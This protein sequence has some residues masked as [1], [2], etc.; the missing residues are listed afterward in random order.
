M[1][2]PR[3]RFGF[4]RFVLALLLGVGTCWGVAWL[5]EPKPLWRMALSNSNFLSS[6]FTSSDNK[7]GVAYCFKIVQNFMAQC[8]N[9]CIYECQSGRILHD[10]QVEPE[11]FGREPFV[12]LAQPRIVN[13]IFWRLSSVM[14]EK[15]TIY[16]LRA[17]DYQH[18]AKDKVVQ[19]WIIETGQHFSLTF[20]DDQ[21]PYFVT[22]MHYPW[23]PLLIGMMQEP[24]SPLMLSLTCSRESKMWIQQ[25]PSELA[26][27]TLILGWN[28]TWKLPDRLE[29]SIQPLASWLLPVMRNVWPPIPGPELEWVVLSPSSSVHPWKRERPSA[30]PAS[31]MLFDGRTG[32]PRALSDS[33]VGKKCVVRKAGDLL[34][35]TGWYESLQLE[36]M[37]IDP[38]TQ[39]QLQWPA[40][41]R[42]ELTKIREVHSLRSHPQRYVALVN[43]NST[44]NRDG[45]TDIEHRQE[46][47]ILQRQGKDL[48]IIGRVT[49]QETHNPSSAVR[50]IHGSEVVMQTSADAAPE[51]IRQ[52]AGRFAWLK[53]YLEQYWPANGSVI[54]VFDAASG[55][56]LKNFN[57][58]VYVS[59]GRL[60]QSSLV[61]V[62]H[63]SYDNQ[64]W[65]LLEC[66]QLPLSASVYS[67][68]WSRAS[69]IVA[70]L[71][72]V[73]LL[74]RRITL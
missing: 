37:L 19:R 40:E 3:K 25:P 64:G 44:G 54:K 4:W 2:A 35:V 41:L 8:S 56:M 57:R 29:E 69:G 46:A 39:E 23:E 38:V 13:N 43:I 67:P 53:P 73:K 52:L 12:H 1:S 11:P 49:F 47:I 30:E 9:I 17:W 70:F 32:Q 48:Y 27:Q 20:V 6:V 18:H 33:M 22:Q 66:W 28:Q 45:S 58:A 72:F 10:L 34:W 24:W 62:Y 7:L 60:S 61:H 31:V 74:R 65:S 16:E 5:L 36:P 26:K 42:E 14:N 21:S 51:F 55:K 59:F 71:L 68:W 15:Q 50:G 63:R